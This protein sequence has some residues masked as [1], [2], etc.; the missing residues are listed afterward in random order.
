M[1][2]RLTGAVCAFMVVFSHSVAAVTVV[3]SGETYK[4]S[5]DS[6]LPSSEPVNTS[7]PVQVDIRFTIDDYFGPSESML[8]RF[9]EGAPTGSYF[10]TGNLSTDSNS[11]VTHI[12][13]QFTEFHWQ[14]LQG[15]IE[16]SMGAGS[17]EL[18]E[19]MI[20]VAV[21]GQRYRQVFAVGEV[22]IPPA[23]YLFGSGLLGLV[24]M[25]RNKS[26]SLS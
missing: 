2:S 9:N 13:R 26:T 3:N 25:A 19:I 24:G 12:Y 10:Y 8:L 18:D 20:S 17:V 6:L 11:G 16:L 22:P 4:F 5:F 15:F 23:L 14:D 1:K 21:P 7:V